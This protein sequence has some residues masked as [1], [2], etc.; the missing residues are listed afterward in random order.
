MVVDKR[1]Y[2]ITLVVKT[3]E[4]VSPRY[5]YIPEIKMS[6][7]LH[8]AMVGNKVAITKAKKK[9]LNRLEEKIGSP[10]ILKSVVYN[11]MESKIPQKSEPITFKSI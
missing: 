4:L 9:L 5:I 7:V 10:S 2:K 6:E 1:Y 8:S 3:Q 11:F